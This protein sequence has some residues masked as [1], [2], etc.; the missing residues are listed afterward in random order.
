MTNIKISI[1]S[2]T[3]CPWCYVGHRNML[4]AQKQWQQTHPADTFSIRYEPYQLMPEMSKVS[5]DKGDFYR[6]K[7]P[8]Q[9]RF[10]MMR[11][12]LFAIGRNVG[13]NFSMGGRVG[14][15][16]D[17]HRLIHL[18]QRLGTDVGIKTVEG[19]FAAYHEQ[20]RDIADV[21]VLRDIAKQSGVPEEEFQKKIIDSD[22]EGAE[23]DK[24]VLQAR[25]MGIT[26]VPFF[27]IQDRHHLSGGQPPEEFLAIFNKI[28]S[29]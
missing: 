23:V 24:A 27:T 3:V 1:I 9:A 16:R 11:D 19:I 7:F 12:R 15:S 29:E 14:N 8:D 5:V 21:E 10:A 13:L 17:S 28:K 22:G 18:A 4:I 2:D 26:G 20:E 6:Q 25:Y